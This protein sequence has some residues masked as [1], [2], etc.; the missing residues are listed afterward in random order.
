MER[1]IPSL[2]TA[3]QSP[4]SLAAATLALAAWIVRI[5]IVTRPQSQARAIVAQY[6]SDAER[7][8]ALTSLLGFS[9]PAGLRRNDLLPWVRLQL[10]HKNRGLLLLGYIA[11]LLFLSIVAVTAL[12][13][14]NPTPP[15][16][17]KPLPLQP[18]GVRATEYFQPPYGL[19]YY[20]LGGHQ[21]ELPAYPRPVQK[22]DRA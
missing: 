11:T 5:W 13:Q 6:E 14:S 15:K 2:V 1:V 21:V 3:V 19:A 12:N 4:F 22:L 16:P 9:P 17:E 7:N 18:I 20:R 8:R 10:A